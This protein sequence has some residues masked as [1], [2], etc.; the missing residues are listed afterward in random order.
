MFSPYPLLDDGWFVL[1][2]ELLNGKSVELRS[3]TGTVP[4]WS[5]PSLVSA[6]FPNDRWRK[7]SLNIY[8]RDFAAYRTG[9]ARWLANR[10][11]ASH[12]GPWRVKRVRIWYMLERTQPHGDPLPA[13]KILLRDYD[14]T[15]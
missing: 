10:W 6:T 7:L 13:E 1:E 4:D 8:N 5:K 11:N 12:R 3:N 14:V 15:K 2:G 9:Y